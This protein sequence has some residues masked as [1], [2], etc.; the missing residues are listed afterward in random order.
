MVTSTCSNSKSSIIVCLTGRQ[1]DSSKFSSSKSLIT[2]F[3]KILHHMVV[4]FNEIL[5]P[6]MTCNAYIGDC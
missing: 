5:N 3:V 4:Y 1:K 6:L 2:P